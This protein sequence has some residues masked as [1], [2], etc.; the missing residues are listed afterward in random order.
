MPLALLAAVVLGALI[1]ANAG[2]REPERGVQLFVRTNG[3]HTWIMVPIVTPQMDWRLLA[4]ARDI[5]EP[6]L[7]GNYLAIGYGDRDFYLNTPTWADLSLATA[8]AAATGQGTTLIHADH[9][10]DPRADAD[11]RPL[12]VTGA[13]YARLVR[14]IVASFK[15][16]ASGRPIPLLGR[17]Y[18][19][20]DTFY[21]ANG[22]YDAFHTCNEWTGAALRAAGVRTGVWTPTAQ[23]IM[24]R[25]RS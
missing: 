25:L 9:E 14:F 13:Q 5:R 24:W 8:F 22:S 21:E 4:P 20:S 3:V 7:A 2:W 10:R 11:Q 15:R 23:S 17:G 6:R 18:G 12:R 1:P 19:Y 16:D